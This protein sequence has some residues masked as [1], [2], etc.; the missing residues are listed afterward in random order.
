M[1]R[2]ACTEPQCL[3]KGA[4][5]LYPMGSI[6]VMLGYRQVRAYVKR[7]TPVS[8][9]KPNI[10]SFYNFLNVKCNDAKNCCYS[11]SVR[12]VELLQYYK[13]YK[14]LCHGI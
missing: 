4:L 12:T 14:E 2:T 7:R 11:V 5:Y 9:F 3:Y 13:Q 8:C 10:L 6:H 1:G